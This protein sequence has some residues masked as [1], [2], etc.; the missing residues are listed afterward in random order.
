MTLVDIVDGDDGNSE[1][2]EDVFV[3]INWIAPHEPQQFSR[4]LAAA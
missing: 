3:S 1:E 2:K 4:R